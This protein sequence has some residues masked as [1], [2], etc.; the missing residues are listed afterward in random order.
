MTPAFTP[1]FRVRSS[2]SPNALKCRC[3]SACTSSGNDGSSAPMSA[4]T[5]KGTVRPRIHP[6]QYWTYACR[7]FH[8]CS[9][10][11]SSCWV[12]SNTLSRSSRLPPPSECALPFLPAYKVDYQRVGLDSKYFVRSALVRDESSQVLGLYLRDLWSK[13][14]GQKAT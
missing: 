2:H 5:Q 9:I 1:A 4:A 10:S 7:R 14:C 13:I 12:R 6:S 8:G 3:T 11:L